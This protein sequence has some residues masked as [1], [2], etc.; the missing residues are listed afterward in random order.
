MTVVM[1][2]ETPI[3]RGSPRVVVTFESG[4]Y[5]VRSQLR[6]PLSRRW[7]DDSQAL[8]RFVN[9]ADAQDY[10]LSIKRPG[11]VSGVGSAI[12]DGLRGGPAFLTMEAT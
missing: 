12:C 9:F 10:A 5:V 3:E 6:S 2:I 1:S 7:R 8:G 11:T 4:S